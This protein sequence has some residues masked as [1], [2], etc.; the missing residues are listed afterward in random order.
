VGRI[1]LWRP[2]RKHAHEVD[3]EG[4]VVVVGDGERNLF[5][6]ELGSGSE[7]GRTPNVAKGRPR[8]ASIGGAFCLFGPQAHGRYRGA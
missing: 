4:V 2:A 3:G 8:L 6:L 1:H 7:G 5:V